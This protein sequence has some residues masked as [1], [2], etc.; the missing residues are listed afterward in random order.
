MVIFV[1][2]E[3]RKH[4]QNG[5]CG[6]LIFAQPQ[7]LPDPGRRRRQALKVFALHAKANAKVKAKATRCLPPRP[8]KDDD[9]VD[10]LQAT[11]QPASTTL[12]HP[13][14]HADIQTHTLSHRYARESLLAK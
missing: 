3:M 11:L 7:G 14:H 4:R 2:R 8:R 10:C 1:F 6:D 12:T 9:P 5:R 13:I